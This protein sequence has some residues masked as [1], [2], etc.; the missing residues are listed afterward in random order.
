[1]RG[2]PVVL[3]VDAGPIGAQAGRAARGPLGA[4]DKVSLVVIPAR[5]LNG[6]VVGFLE[7]RRALSYNK[8]YGFPIAPG[9]SRVGLDE[10]TRSSM[11]GAGVVTD[12]MGS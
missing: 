1:M 2:A 5:R 12:G 11:S 9:P 10:R 8:P 6:N 3:V 7:I 4:A